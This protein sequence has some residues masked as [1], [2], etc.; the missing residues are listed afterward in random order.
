MPGWLHRLHEWATRNPVSRVDDP[1]LGQL[2]LNESYWECKVTSQSGPIVL[3]IGGRYE[4]DP[5]LI[6]TAR[7]TYS[8]IDAFVDRGMEY[9]QAESHQAAWEPL[10][11]EILSLTIRDINY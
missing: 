4:P 8:S 3:G 2:L 1:V 5:A 11:N 7:A 10:A 9:L 6:E